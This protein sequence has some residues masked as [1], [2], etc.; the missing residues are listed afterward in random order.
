M[1]L[2]TIYPTKVDVMNVASLMRSNPLLRGALIAPSVVVLVFAFFN[3][4]GAVDPTEAMRKVTVA[5]VNQDDGLPSP[6][7]TMRLSEQMVTNL[8]RQLPFT[9]TALPDPAAA[10]AALDRGE[11]AAALVLPPDFSRSVAGNTP[12]RATVLNSD[13]LSTIETQVS[14][15]LPGQLQGALSL[16]VMGARAEMAQRAGGLALV[17]NVQTPAAAPMPPVMIGVDTLHTAADAT[18]LAAPFVLG[19]SAWLAALIGSILLFV[20][21]RPLVRGNPREV[22]VLRAV[23]PIGSALLAGG[24]AALIVASVTG[25]WGSFLELWGYRWVVGVAA[26]AIITALFALFGFAALLVAVPLVFYQGVASGLMAPVAATPSWLAWIN[27][28]LPL[29]QMATGLRTILIGGPEGSVP[30]LSTSV[31]ALVAMTLIVAG[32]AM[33]SR[34]PAKVR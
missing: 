1:Y 29:P 8:T 5:V 3:L 20:A 9:I 27:D 16:M 12:V 2:H 11:I 7:G 18:T 30:W 4:T 26:M 23:L 25:E 33:W 10:R 15:T 24:M 31:T 6:T 28:V 21:T 32:T 34:M 17:A 19:F 22:A 14:R 13:H